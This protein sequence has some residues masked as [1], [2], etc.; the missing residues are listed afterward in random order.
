M[1]VDRLPARSTVT[2]SPQLLLNMD[3][4]AVGVNL[5]A[6]VSATSL[7]TWEGSSVTNGAVNP[8]LEF[9]V[10]YYSQF[11]FENGSKKEQSDS[12]PRHQIEIM[13][14]N[15]P[16]DGPRH[17]VDSYVAAGEDFQLTWF[18]S[19]PVVYQVADAP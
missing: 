18:I 16:A 19:C 1:L 15:F 13:S 3:Q 7:N 2:T 17:I 12:F 5:Q 9:E 11:L 4:T 10:P 6:N 8:T 14:H